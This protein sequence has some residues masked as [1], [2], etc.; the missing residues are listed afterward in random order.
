VCQ[1]D[2][3]AQHNA[4][5][6]GPWLDKFASARHSQTNKYVFAKRA[7]AMLRCDNWTGDITSTRPHPPHSLF[8]FPGLVCAET[9][10]FVPVPSQTLEIYHAAFSI[11]FYFATRWAGLFSLSLCSRLLFSQSKCR[12]ANL[13]TLFLFRRCRE[14]TMRA[15][16]RCLTEGNN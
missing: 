14:Q 8:C 12:R 2:T 5:S 15:R 13:I 3:A 4:F 9:P 1:S 16:A 6:L 11:Y 10:T 7:R